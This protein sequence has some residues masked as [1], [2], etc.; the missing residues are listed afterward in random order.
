MSG[1]KMREEKNVCGKRIK[2]RR[3][4]LGLTQAQFAARMELEGILWDQKIV[5]RVELQLRTVMDFE[6]QA[7]ANVLD[8]SLDQLIYGEKKRKNSRRK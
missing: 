2:E 7:V 4:E 6:L 5:S 3:L 8:I 1:R